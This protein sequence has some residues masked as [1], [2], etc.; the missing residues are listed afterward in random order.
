VTHV[1]GVMEIEMLDHCGE[2]VRVVVHIVTVAGLGRATVTPAVRR[3]HAVAVL[4][5]EQHLGVPVIGRQ[6]PAVTEHDRLPVAPVLEED[7]RP[8]TRRDRSHAC[9][10]RSFGG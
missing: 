1:D 10:L 7:L 9:Y 2:V 4:K 6:R 8:V 5:E 3:D